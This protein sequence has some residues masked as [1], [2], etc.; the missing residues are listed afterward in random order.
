MFYRNNIL[1]NKTSINI[2]EL[3]INIPEQVSSE[4]S[5]DEYNVSDILTELSDDYND[6]IS[7]NKKNV[8]ADFDLL[9][10]NDKMFK[11][12]Y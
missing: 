10:P 5:S 8:L 1:N 2:G 4:S 6:L 11:R 3:D 12:V 7:T 9:K